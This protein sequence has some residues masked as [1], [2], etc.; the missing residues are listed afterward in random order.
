MRFTLT[1]LLLAVASLSFVLVWF[2]PA[3]VEISERGFTNDIYFWSEF[4]RLSSENE[5][6]AWNR[7]IP[8]A[9]SW[10]L[11][12]PTEFPVDF[13]TTDFVVAPFPETAEYYRTYSS[14]LG[15]AITTIHGTRYNEGK[16]MQEIKIPNH[17]HLFFSQRAFIIANDLLVIAAVGLLPQAMIAS[18][19]H[20]RI[21]MR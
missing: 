11:S 18:W 13:N 5:Y 3:Q 6:L 10:A 1:N 15:G 9:A 2:T 19:R 4:K 16:V 12:D 17:T 7:A 8:E 14:R 20:H 21:T